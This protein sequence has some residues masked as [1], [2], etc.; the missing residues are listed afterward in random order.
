MYFFMKLSFNM[1][2]WKYTGENKEGKVWQT[3]EHRPKDKVTLTVLNLIKQ[4][5][6]NHVYLGT[7]LI[8]IHWEHVNNNGCNLVEK[9]NQ[10]I[11]QRKEIESNYWRRRNPAI[12]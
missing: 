8:L 9:G 11:D 1:H 12:P 2:I 6:P 10:E 4:Y 3:H 7:T 5:K